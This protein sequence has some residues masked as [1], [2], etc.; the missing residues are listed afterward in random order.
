[1]PQAY[2]FDNTLGLAFLLSEAVPVPVPV[3]L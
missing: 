1:M 2:G 3:V